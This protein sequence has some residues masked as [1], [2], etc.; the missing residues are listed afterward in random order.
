[1]LIALVG[2][3]DALPHAHE[4]GLLL[5]E[6][7]RA[8][9]VLEVLEQDLDLVARLEIGHVLELLERDRPFGLE[10]DVEDHEVLADLEDA[11]LDDLAFLNRRQRPVVQLH[12]PLVLVGRELVLLVELGAAVGEGAELA[13]LQVALFARGQ[14]AV[15][16]QV[17]ELG[18]EFGSKFGAHWGGLHVAGLRSPRRERGGTKGPDW[19]QDAIRPE[20]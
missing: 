11:R 1:M 19:H 4:V 16:R 13:L 7:D 18:V 2:H 10:P 5:R 14:L 20:P 17:R 8:L 9:L 12:H 6:D 3:A 15:G